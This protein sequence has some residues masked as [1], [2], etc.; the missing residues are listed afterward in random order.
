MDRQRVAVFTGRGLG[1]AGCQTHSR[2]WQVFSAV[3][4]P[5]CVACLACLSCLGC[6]SPSLSVLPLQVCVPCFFSAHLASRQ[7]LIFVRV[8]LH[9]PFPP[10][11]VD[12]RVDLADMALWSRGTKIACCPVITA[13]H[14][15]KNDQSTKPIAS[16]PF[17][18]AACRLMN[19]NA[20]A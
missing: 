16:S 2:L 1:A 17:D 14:C 4:F 6:F 10:V 9:F 5:P 8:C 12:V 11:G 13:L 7:P 15:D 19:K 3:A 18:L 20:D